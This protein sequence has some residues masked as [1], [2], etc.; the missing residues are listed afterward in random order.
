MLRSVSR[1]LKLT[2]LLIAPLLLCGCVRSDVGI[3]FDNPQ[4]GEIIQQIQISD[5]LRGVNQTA[6]EQ[7]VKTIEQQ[8]QAIGGEIQRLPN[9]NLRVRIPFQNATDLETKFNRF[10]NLTATGTGLDLPK[11]ESHLSLTHHNLLLLE[12]DRLEYDVDL[13]SLGVASSSGNVLLSPSGLVDLEFRLETPWGAQNMV[14]S[15]QGTSARSSKNQL[16]WKLIPGEQNHLEAAFWLPSPIGIGTVIILLLI[17][18]GQY[19]KDS[20]S[21]AAEV[22][23]LAAI[24]QTENPST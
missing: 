12:R 9:Q 5:R 18:G 10:F 14:K 21:S 8:S 13:R 4:R 3:H 6:T 2:V 15:S 24:V 20:R 16:I 7:W 1:L 17:I 11:I 22:A 19:L 23:A